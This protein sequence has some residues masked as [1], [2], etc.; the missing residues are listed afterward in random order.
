MPAGVA[1][2]PNA[3]APALNGTQ[4]AATGTAPAGGGMPPAQG[5][6]AG[7]LLLPL[8]LLGFLVFMIVMQVWTGKKEKKKRD[9]L[10]SSLG[11]ND[12]VM[13]TGGIVG[14]IAEIHDQELVI[15]TDESSNTRIRVVKS[16]V[17]SV[18]KKSEGVK[19]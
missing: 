18:L 19:S 12:K 9:E 7:M 2:A 6:G 16:A 15:R 13:T 17:A 8:M 5:G 10:M 14:H 1:P 3:A 4:Q 11:R